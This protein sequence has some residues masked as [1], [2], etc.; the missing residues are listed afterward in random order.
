M[1]HDWPGNIRELENAIEYA[2]ILCRDGLIGPEHLPHHLRAGVLPFP[3][4]SG[5]TLQDIEKRAIQE[6]LERNGRRRMATARELG[7]DKNTL[8]RK[9]KRFGIDTAARSEPDE[10]SPKE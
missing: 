10:R 1:H 2:F 3:A 5:M 7:I 6:A 9:I 4:A 8:R